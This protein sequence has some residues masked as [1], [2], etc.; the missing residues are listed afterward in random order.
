MNGQEKIQN[1]IDSPYVD[2]LKKYMNV[3][4]HKEGRNHI[5]YIDSELSEIEFTEDEV[6]ELRRIE[7][8]P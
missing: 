3:I 7:K 6:K 2:L 8:L 5:D 4:K 1:W